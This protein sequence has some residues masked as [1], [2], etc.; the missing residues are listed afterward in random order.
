[1]DA[2]GLAKHIVAAQQAEIGQMN[3]ML[4]G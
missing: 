4:E 1:M 3:Q 2:I